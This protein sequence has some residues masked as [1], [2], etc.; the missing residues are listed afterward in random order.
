MLPLYCRKWNNSCWHEVSVQSTPGKTYPQLLVNFVFFTWIFNI[1]KQN[2]TTQPV[3]FYPS[4]WHWN[5]ASPSSEGLSMTDMV[6]EQEA[7][8]LPNAHGLNTKPIGAL[9][10][11]ADLLWCAASLVSSLASCCSSSVLAA[12]WEA[13]LGSEW[14]SEGGR[15]RELGAGHAIGNHI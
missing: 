8:P 1:K 2:S 10:T 13:P 5:P 12:T 4:A 3:F 11:R 14:W 6:D 7:N 15:K 9:F